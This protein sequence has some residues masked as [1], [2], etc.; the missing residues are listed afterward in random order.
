MVI[1]FSSYITNVDGCFNCGKCV[2][3]FLWCSNC[4]CTRYCSKLCQKELW[5]LHKTE[6]KQ[7]KQDRL[8]LCALWSPSIHLAPQT[9]FH[10]PNY[11]L[12]NNDGK[13]LASR[14]LNDMI[15]P[16][17]VKKVNPNLSRW[18][19]SLPNI[20]FICALI[21]TN[22]PPQVFNSIITVNGINSFSELYNRRHDAFNNSLIELP[23]IWQTHLYRIVNYIME[24]NTFAKAGLI[25]DISMIG[26]NN[27]SLETH[28]A[29][30]GDDLMVAVQQEDGTW[31]WRHNVGGNVDRG[32]N[33][34][35][36]SS[37]S[38][39][40]CCVCNKPASL[41]CSLCGQKTY[42]DAVCQK[43][44]WFIQHKRLCP[45]TRN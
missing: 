10:H 8:A 3:N 32:L 30:Q 40:V 24:T 29:I 37:H 36:E 14:T 33:S 18:M 21:K 23:P 22:M 2:S 12:P 44:D 20:H 39:S 38:R 11:R 42:C 26:F 1:S 19:M 4:K 25:S 13:V 17:D 16:D 41:Q 28:L 35:V 34:F 45:R 7:V 27:N 43:H 9:S 31:I 6:C 5:T 15:L